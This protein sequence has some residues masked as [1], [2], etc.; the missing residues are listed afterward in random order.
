[1]DTEKTA[2]AALTDAEIQEKAT[3]RR[4][5]DEQREVYHDKNGMTK[6]YIAP[7]TADNYYY[8]DIFIPGEGSIPSE[9]GLKDTMVRKPRPEKKFG[10]KK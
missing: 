10:K 8:C 4:L 9:E 5:I 1:M 2:P 6:K 7:F 3:E